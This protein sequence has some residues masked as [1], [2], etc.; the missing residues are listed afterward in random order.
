M[1]FKI[2]DHVK[3]R[4]GGD[5]IFVIRKI[6]PDKY[7]LAED[8]AGYTVVGYDRF[9]FEL[10]ASQTPTHHRFQ[11]GN[12]VVCVGSSLPHGKVYK[13]VYCG[14]HWLD[15]E[16]EV[17]YYAVQDF[18]LHNAQPSEFAKLAFS[19]TDNTTY[20][21]W[22]GD[23]FKAGY[24]GHDH[25]KHSRESHFCQDHKAQYNGFTESYSYC[26]ICDKKNI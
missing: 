4:Y 14:K 13:V 10:V 1:S 19:G 6:G 26:T 7:I 25:L 8:I 9:D 5:T 24:G 20:A 12:L 22:P 17:G 15:L 2:G 23:K 11:P 18:E 16:N 21:L 3:L